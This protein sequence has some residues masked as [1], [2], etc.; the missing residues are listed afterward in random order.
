MYTEIR[1]NPLLLTDA[2][3]LSHDA[4]KATTDY[5]TSHIY[6][7]K[8]GMILFGFTELVTGFLSAIEVTHPMIDE[9]V[10]KAEAFHLTFPEALFRRVVDELGGRIPLRVQC[11]PEGMYCPP[12]TPF[13]QVTNTVPGFASLVTWWEGI[14]LQGHFASACATE[15]MHMRLYLEELRRKHGYDE[16]F[17]TRFHSFGFRGHRSLEDAY[18]AGRA[19]SLFLTSSDDFHISGHE[20]DCPLSS[21]PALAHLVVQQFD[22][23]MTCFTR[24]IDVAVKEGAAAVALV[25]DTYDAYNVIR[26]M[27]VPLAK[28]AEEKGLKH[29][30]FRPD[31]G[32]TW[33]QAVDIYDV[34]S[35]NG[36]NKAP[37]LSISVIIGEGMSFSEAKKADIFFLKNNV[38]LTFISYGIGA[39][40]YKHIHRDTLGW[41]MKTGH[42]N[43]APR[44]KFS[45]N[46][47]KRSIP[48]RL[49]VTYQGSKLLA[50]QESELSEG[51]EGQNLYGDVYWFDSSR[52]TSETETG[53]TMNLNVMKL[54]LRQDDIVK[55]RSMAAEE[56]ADKES[57]DQ[58]FILTSQKTKDLVRLFVE[59]YKK[60]R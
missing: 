7:R 41:A 45:E 38:P 36:L 11:L 27:I 18:W 51:N 6:N 37:D 10:R 29:L 40:F 13:A 56:M 28:H 15:A 25:I 20:A 33:K 9:A 34:V 17:L 54:H 19:W 58:V 32:D 50:I 39:G 5:E 26:N 59:K 53:S 42:S 2:Y 16:G 31:S 4:F 57:L 43:G 23:E 3:S 48:G 49:A 24:A 35:N 44:M 60:G 47:L 8:Q 14:F 30:V 46:P 55:T 22:D 12:G 52:L 1:R 21:I